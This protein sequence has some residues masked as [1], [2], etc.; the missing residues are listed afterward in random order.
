VIDTILFPSCRHASLVLISVLKAAFNR[1]R[2]FQGL[3]Y[4]LYKRSQ[5]SM[6][7]ASEISSFYHAKQSTCHFRHIKKKEKSIA[8]E[9]QCILV[10]GGMLLSDLN[11]SISSN[12]GRQRSLCKQS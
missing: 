4:K 5:Q 10:D 12:A 1:A 9:I 6:H 3:G 11:D 7:L 2:L 8:S